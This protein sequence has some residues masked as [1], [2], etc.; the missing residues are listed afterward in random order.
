MLCRLERENLV[1]SNEFIKVEFL[2][3]VCIECTLLKQIFARYFCGFLCFRCA[4]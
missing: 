3:Y 1:L 2:D 4:I